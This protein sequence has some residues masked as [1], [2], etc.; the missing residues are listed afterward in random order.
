[1]AVFQATGMGRE[2]LLFAILR[3]LVFEIPALYLLNAAWPLYGLSYAQFVSE[4]LTAVLAMIVLLRFL[5]RFTRGG[6]APQDGAIA[7]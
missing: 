4:T 2:S 7:T 1:M 3:K 5:R 6:D